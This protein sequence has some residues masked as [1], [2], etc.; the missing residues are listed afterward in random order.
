MNG[1]AHFRGPAPGQH[2]SEDTGPGT[3][4]LT[5]RTD[6]VSLIT[7]LIGPQAKLVKTLKKLLNF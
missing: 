3:E 1:M 7:E 4:P 6:R 2:S 5:Y